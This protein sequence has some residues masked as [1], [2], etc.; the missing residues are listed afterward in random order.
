LWEEK[1]GR[2]RGEEEE[3]G[4]TREE[5]KRRRRGEEEEKV[6]TTLAFYV[7]IRV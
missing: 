2:K 7:R 5:K 4:H 6:H 1:G 3:K